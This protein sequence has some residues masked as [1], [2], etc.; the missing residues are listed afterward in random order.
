M[1]KKVLESKQNTVI[2]ALENSEADHSYK[3]KLN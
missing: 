1:I 2:R 3:S